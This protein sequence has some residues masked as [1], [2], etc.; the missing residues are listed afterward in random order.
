M[1][2]GCILSILFVVIESFR[3]IRG[4]LDKAEQYDKLERDMPELIGQ[5]EKKVKFITLGKRSTLVFIKPNYF[6]STSKH[7]PHPLSRTQKTKKFFSLKI[8]KAP[9]LPSLSIDL[10]YRVLVPRFTLEAN[11]PL[12]LQ[13][14]K[15]F[16]KNFLIF[17]FFSSD[18]LRGAP[19]RADP[20]I[21]HDK[22]S[23]PTEPRV[24]QLR[25]P[26][27]HCQQ[28]QKSNRGRRLQHL[29]DLLLTVLLHCPEQ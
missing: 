2:F 25:Q 9:T 20:Q 29:L 26:P 22:Q 3:M 16:G 28:L 17:N 7:P 18:Q 15:N 21:Q 6:Q 14:F 5:I 12:F 23:L 4:K 8:N 10:L 1:V 11:N 13:N 27:L 24:Q 19:N